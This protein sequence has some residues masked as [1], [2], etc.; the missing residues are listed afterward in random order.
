MNL[1]QAMDF[2]RYHGVV[3]QSAKGLEPSLVV[4]IVGGPIYGSWWGHPMGRVIYARANKIEKSKA[5]LVCTLASGK[6][7]YIHRRLWPA[8]VRMA[9]KFPGHSLDKVQQIHLPSGRHQR[10]DI[11]FPNWVPGTVLD[12]AERLSTPEASA[13]I[14]V[15]L[16]RYGGA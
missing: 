9:G 8:F 16:Q 10:Q 15:W 5:V 4:R 11:Q 14:E 7:T 3:L 12:S 2:I 1:R 6:I 13:E